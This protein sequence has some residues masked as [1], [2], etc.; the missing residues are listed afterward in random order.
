METTSAPA[1]QRVAADPGLPVYAPYVLTRE[2]A[3][4]FWLVGTLWLVPASGRQTNNRFALLEQAM[5][6]GLGPPTH[7]HPAAYEGFYILE[8][9]CTFNA[10][11]QSVPAG[12][13]TF[14]SI[15][16]GLPHSFSVDGPEA[17]A[18]NFYLPAGFELVAM[19][20]AQPALERRRPTL[21]ESAPTHSRE[22]IQILSDLYG[23]QAVTAL[24]F[25]LP[26]TPDLLATQPADVGRGKLVFA[27]AGQVPAVRRFGLEWRVLAATADTLGTYDLLEVTAPAGTG[28][29][30]YAAGQDE[31]LYVL[32]GTLTLTVFGQPERQLA[33]GALAYLPAGSAVAWQAQ[34]SEARLLVFHL[35]GGFD[36]ALAAAGDDSQAVA[37][38]EKLGTRFLPSPV[39][40]QP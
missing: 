15:P 9:T 16:K 13:G 29:P 27:T 35:P 22:Q 12:P 23:Q 2:T 28:M 33:A 1:D 17:R 8:G 19:S 31:V 6:G 34:G 36:R 30:R 14:V 26:P 24:P 10:Q 39:V 11:G 3:P 21:P 20:L 32:A 40:P 7:R 5:A 18:L 4:A 38:L 25:A 37:E